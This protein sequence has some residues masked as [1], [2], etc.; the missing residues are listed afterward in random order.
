MLAYWV[1]QAGSI[2]ALDWKVPILLVATVYVLITGPLQTLIAYTNAAPEMRKHR[3]WF[4]AYLV[5]AILYSE[6]MTLLARVAHLRQLFG[7]S[8]WRVTPRSVEDTPSG[9]GI[10]GRFW[11]GGI[12]PLEKPPKAPPEPVSA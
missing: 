1:V 8:E 12:A 5:V 10:I 3:G 11:A 2:N 7:E 9:N 4:L 6:Y